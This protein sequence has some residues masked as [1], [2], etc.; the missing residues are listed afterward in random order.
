MPEKTYGLG[1]VPGPPREDTLGRPAGARWDRQSGRAGG[2]GDGRK[3]CP[4][5]C[6]RKTPEEAIEEGR[7][8]RLSFW[9]LPAV[10]PRF[11]S[12]LR[13]LLC[14]YGDAPSLGAVFFLLVHSSG[15]MGVSDMPPEPTSLEEPLCCRCQVRR[16]R[17]GGSAAER[18][19]LTGGGS[20]GARLGVGRG[21]GSGEV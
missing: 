9:V 16:S 5:R 2:H 6:A 8:L 7:D 18:R 14:P 20:G 19:H 21:S 10:L 17:P 1:R 4:Q 3:V 12:F 11:M 15:E 13:A